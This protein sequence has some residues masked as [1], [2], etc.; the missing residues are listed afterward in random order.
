MK[1]KR[2]RIFTV[3]LSVLLVLAVVVSGI[4]VKTL[5][6]T[7]KQ[8]EKQYFE[9]WYQLSLITEQVAEAAEA[10]RELSG[11][12]HTVNVISTFA[13]FVL[14]DS[15]EFVHIDYQTFINVVARAVPGEKSDEARILL[16]QLSRRIHEICEGVVDACR[17]AS[18]MAGAPGIPE[19]S[20]AAQQAR[21]DILALEQQYRDTMQ[22]MIKGLQGG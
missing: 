9:Q 8:L 11:L 15:W 18:G 7:R 5:L 4:S 3:A 20:P 12:A 17:D 19:D 14:D 16:A 1:G 6:Q 10:G 22:R 2:S 21:L 13:R